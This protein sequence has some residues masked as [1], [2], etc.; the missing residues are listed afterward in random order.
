MFDI[1]KIAKSMMPENNDPLGFL[2]DNSKNT[3]MG[4][5]K[6]YDDE[7]RDNEYKRTT[8]AA[9]YSAR[10]GISYAEA[11]DGLDA[12][13]E[14][15]FKEKV[16]IKTAY[17]K[18]NE[19]LNA[20]YFAQQKQ[21]KEQNLQRAKYDMYSLTPA[22]MISHDTKEMQQKAQKAKELSAAAGAGYVKLSKFMANVGY[23]LS[24]IG[25]QNNFKIVNDQ[26]Y[27]QLK[28]AAD[29]AADPAVKRDLKTGA[30]EVNTYYSGI[31]DELAAKANFK[32][33]F[34][35]SSTDVMDF[36]DNFIKMIL[37]E[38]PSQATQFMLS[39]ATGGMSAPILGMAYTLDKETELELNNP[40]IPEGT[41][42]LNA[43]ATGVINSLD[44]LVDVQIIKSVSNKE[45]KASVMKA[46]ALYVSNMGM[47]AGTEAVQTVAE[48]AVDLL[49][50]VH[51]DY[52]KMSA[53]QKKKILLNGVAES[54]LLGAAF[55][56]G[57]T[58]VAHH[59]M[60]QLD[61]EAYKVKGELQTKA[62]EI[63]AKDNPTDAEI[64]Y[65][66]QIERVIETSDP[67][68]II[69]TAKVA[70]IM[71]DLQS[72]QEFASDE[73]LFEAVGGDEDAFFK[74]KADAVLQN[75]LLEQGLQP[76]FQK[77]K[78]VVNDIQRRFPDVKIEMTQNY[79]TLSDT[80][81]QYYNGRGYGKG[82][83][84][85]YN[86]KTDTVVI[87]ADN[88]KNTDHLEKTFAHETAGHKGLQALLGNEYTSI[89]DEIYSAVNQKH[90]A[91]LQ[92]LAAT[93]GQDL[94]TIEGQRYIIEEYLA[95]QADLQ[96][97]SG[98]KSFVQKIKLALRK[99][100]FRAK[101]TDD[102][103]TTLMRRSLD[104]VRKQRSP[105]TGNNNGARFSIIG[106]K[107]AAALD[108]YSYQNNLDNLLT[109][110]QMLEAGKDAAD[111]KL[112]T[113]W[114]KGGDGKW[115][116]EI[117]DVKLKT[118][119]HFMDGEEY[120]RTLWDITHTTNGSLEEYFEAP[121]L[122]AA[123]PQLKDINFKIITLPNGYGGWYSRVKNEIAVSDHN[124]IFYMNGIEKNL[125]NGNT[126]YAD[127][128]K[129]QF[130]AE[131][132]DIATHEIQHAIQYIEGFAK[133]GTLRQFENNPQINPTY[134]K[135]SEDIK[136]AEEKFKNSPDFDLI[137]KYTELLDQWDGTESEEQLRI[138]DEINSIYEQLKEHGTWASVEKYFDDLA[139]L[140]TVQKN[141]APMDSYKALAG[142]V[143]ARNAAERTDMSAE[144]KRNSLLAETEDV[145]EESKIYIFDNDGTSELARGNLEDIENLK[146]YAK[147]LGVPENHIVFK[148]LSR[149]GY[150]SNGRNKV[151]LESN[152]VLSGLG[153]HI[154][155]IGKST[156]GGIYF[157]EFIDNFE[158][159]FNGKRHFNKKSMEGFYVYSEPDGKPLYTL[160]TY[161]K[162]GKEYFK[163]F[164]GHERGEKETK[165]IVASLR[166]SH[167][168]LS[169]LVLINPQPSHNVSPNPEKSS[170]NQENLR[171][172]IAPVIEIEQ[173]E[174]SDPLDNEY[175]Q[176]MVNLRDQ[177]LAD[178]LNARIFE[179]AIESY[180]FTDE[181]PNWAE[182]SEDERIE[183]IH[184]DFD[185]MIEEEEEYL[186]SE[187]QSEVRSEQGHNE[188]SA[189]NKAAEITR[190][191]AEELGYDVSKI[192][193]NKNGTSFYITV[194]YE[195]SHAAWKLRI[196]DHPQPPGGS[197][198]ER[199]WGGGRDKAD[200]E[201]V[202][203]N[204]KIDLSPIWQ[205]LEEHA[206]DNGVRFSVSPQVDT[207]AFKNWF[208]DS[209]VVDENG[210]PLVVYHGSSAEFTVFSHKFAMRNGAAD[211]RGFYFTSDKSKAEGYKTEDGKLFEV[212]LSLQNPLNPNELT[213]TKNEI[214][215]IIRA[216]D[217]DGDY[218]SNYAEDDRGYPGKAWF[219]KAVKRAAT[220]I[221]ES[222]DDNADIIAEI[223]SSFGQGDA[224][225]K[226]TETIGYDGFIKDDVFVVFNPTQIKSATDNV[227]TFDP[228]NPDIRFSVS[229]GDGFVSTADKENMIT[230][231]MGVPKKDLDQMNAAS[232][233]A[234]LT[235]KKFN[236]P[237][238]NVAL[239]ALNTAKARRKEQM[240]R[241]ADKRRHDWL[242][243]NVDFYR[244][245][246]DFA[247]ED[248]TIRP[249]MR[250]KDEEFSGSF[251]A[252]EFR[253]YGKKRR[254]RDNESDKQ[255]KNY[256]NRREK[257]LAKAQGIYSDELA[258]H[259]ANEYGQD[260]S[261]VEQKLIDFFRDLKWSDLRKMYSDYVAGQNAEFKELDKRME[262]EWK[263][264]QDIVR[265]EE[266]YDII[267]NKKAITPEW[268]RDNR[269]TFNLL[270]KTVLNEDPPKNIPGKKE[271]AAF[272]VAMMNQSDNAPAMKEAFKI[273]YDELYLQFNDKFKDFKE[274]L[275]ADKVN[276]REVQT[277]AKDFA[278]QHIDR[279]YREQFISRAIRLGQYSKNPTGKY[280]QGRRQFELEKLMA[281]M[282]E[283][284]ENLSKQKNI[285]EINKLLKNNKT[286][287]TAK[288]VPFSDM[289]ERQPVIDRIA[290][291][292]KMSPETVAGVL[293]YE[294]ETKQSLIENIEQLND[295]DNDDQQNKIAEM[296]NQLHKIEND[297]YYLQKFGAL[298]LK[299]A[300]A[301][302]NALNA[303]NQFIHEGKTEF[304]E[305]KL[306]AMEKFQQMRINIRKEMNLGSLT[307]PA[308]AE[309]DKHVNPVDNYTYMSMSLPDMLNIFSNTDSMTAYDQSQ[310]GQFNQMIDNATQTEQTM[311]LDMQ[312]KFEKTLA[313]YGIDSIVKRGKFLRG[314]MQEEDTGVEI[315]LYAPFVKNNQPDWTKGRPRT[316]DYVYVDHAR[317]ILEDYNAGHP[318]ILLPIRRNEI[319][320]KLSVMKAIREDFKALKANIGATFTLA[321]LNDKTI[322][323]YTDTEGGNT[324]SHDFK[325][326]DLPNVKKFME[327]KNITPIKMSSFTLH[328][329]QEQLI[330]YDAGIT[331][332]A[333]NNMG[334]D[335]DI[336]QWREH[337]DR[338]YKKHDTVY[339]M[340]ENP[341][342]M[343]K[344][345][346]LKL[347][348][349]AAVQLIL[350]WEQDHYRP[351]MEWNGYSEQT[352][353]QLKVFLNKKNPAYLAV[354]Y[355]LRDYVKEHQ[356]AL[357][358]AVFER[359][360]VHLPEQQNFWYADFG[361]NA[362]DQVR[363]AGFGNQ[364][365][366]LTVSAN[367]LTGR[368]LHWNAPSTHANAFTL[369]LRKQ[370][371]QAH[372]VAW[373]QPIRTLRAVYNDKSVQFTMIKNFGQ[374]AWNQFKQK[375]EVLASGG[376]AACAIG[377]FFNQF[378]S[379][380]TPSNIA[381]NPASAI[382]QLVG[383]LNYAHYVPVDKLLKYLPEANPW[384]PEYRQWREY[385]MRQDFLK[386]R[387]HGAGLNPN[388]GGLLNYSQ[389]GKNISPVSDAVMQYSLIMT[390]GSDA[391]S[392]TTWGY[393][394]FK[395]FEETAKAKG[396]KD[397]FDFAYRWW[398]KATE[399]TQQ[400]GYLKDLNRFSQSSGWRALTIYM[401]NPM[402]T[403][404]LELTA[405][406]KML[407]NPTT[408]NKKDFLKKFIVNH[409]ISSTAMNL[410]SSIFRHG[411]D[412]EEWEEDL[413]N[414]IAGWLLGSFDS[415]FVAGQMATGLIAVLS[416]DAFS[417]LQKFN[418]LPMFN[419]LVRDV[420]NVRKM[421]K[422][423]EFDWLD[424]LNAIG[425]IMMMGGPIKTRT[426]GFAISA[427]TKQAK[428][429]RRWFDED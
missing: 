88:I 241:L 187:S 109:A 394:A 189:L 361:G 152:A 342:Y 90:G 287:R 182:M 175:Y 264:Q 257:A 238:E 424:S 315:D 162:N 347:T 196:S 423:G 135:V 426:A 385:V 21:Q 26:N 366:G 25:A 219:D 318:I 344:K 409:L 401:T 122:F 339:F 331:P 172:S 34:A 141:L 304:R 322:R 293:R 252:Q 279:G 310:A 15:Y 360:G 260:A 139:F 137:Q 192:N 158:K 214:E 89:I 160:R 350:T 101:W 24:K 232:A 183:H 362:I 12:F 259:I 127:F 33:D 40:E 32:A 236:V 391:L 422:N 356:A 256:L 100:G 324:I 352:I 41:R 62:Q 251:I 8:L 159:A 212:Y 313:Q 268:I 87:F 185:G 321:K 9:Y 53:E 358:K 319:T 85:Y 216:I 164:Y 295:A 179:N 282:L 429:V 226:I 292:V 328:G 399:K 428:R 114:E 167:R 320:D 202:I 341:E 220:M 416:D 69:Q 94:N 408:G 16:D 374:A 354:G 281:E 171:F 388:I 116:M 404:A 168:L 155:E 303:L 102:E 6:G 20:A 329:V 163:S 71:S 198:R 254:Q 144:E 244:H 64:A 70:N 383:G 417:A 338:N 125:A 38:A 126:E 233:M 180:P 113:G 337:I 96:K 371:E 289:R 375:I 258:Q 333:Q 240:K 205:F 415:L 211:G 149:Q 193:I 246:V 203:Q 65:L 343:T 314:T 204:D 104:N 84:G 276:V 280:P 308:A 349:G 134:K 72:Q 76:D 228:N 111:I 403:A 225:A 412:F 405:L 166:T 209:K 35:S 261:E 406:T 45:L 414:Y 248:F 294:F 157:Q 419:D 103:I 302:E 17:N 291:I 42:L 117:P 174:G 218:V 272:N 43:F 386:N 368:R 30:T 47:E 381:L 387:L 93:Y 253:K 389:K 80:E 97:L 108:E 119:G 106:E 99:V 263:R 327:Q 355:A 290:Q 255:Y 334:D 407:K 184:K 181:F 56:G 230:V 221:Y 376:E 27:A 215:K 277:A 267:N 128:L 83:G 288:N 197:Y 234:Y 239:S 284:Q 5:Y 36:A 132:Q 283:F 393:A 156:R 377:S 81:K 379:K 194:D 311:L 217:V 91:E 67:M 10:M 227:G 301:V 55:G 145:A 66:D 369:F 74:A 112:A 296:L 148:I 427:F 425:N 307:S 186:L 68:A 29:P 121:E 7:A 176:A 161:E 39:A 60:A 278:Y 266:V 49:S 48:N 245:A 73:E 37:I 191:Y 336:I 207:P 413:D 11:F 140:K 195:D 275:L 398:M 130:F 402:Q 305:S 124:L 118:I 2:D 190:D 213:I 28:T 395:Y 380:W 178:T 247:G 250:F 75:Q 151:Y 86:D 365:G 346:Q 50:G 59:S 370:L 400:S 165:K 138:E 123:Y 285:A 150:I 52:S 129:E 57:T 390:T 44:G 231:L 373:T 78:I 199:E 317:R 222:S 18:L 235:E 300:S 367:F 58:A 348:S 312:N 188:F 210:N 364:S 286:R 382:K 208:K 107:G 298:D 359:Y 363:D 14:Q 396:E 274:K 397:V 105:R 31:Y 249:S 378:Y 410:I 271:L 3:L 326:S 316:T 170:E 120:E 323:V 115:R 335:I 372:F 143:E 79:D 421:V 345:H 273:A 142:E 169:N 265:Q 353:E 92:K 173:F 229:D 243:E 131:I 270:W 306:A 13:N 98:F 147:M 206:P 351:V 54:A 420:T 146:T 242:Y 237:D 309:L 269:A 61:G 4:I 200:V 411:F 153:K 262:E 330:Q 82:Y 19:Q 133:G 392:A 51:G 23:G 332:E 177:N 46:A 299:K 95:D 201:A 1:D 223:Y 63:R 340:G 154:L 136:N 357:D 418:F 224:L 384:N 297:I 22:N 110:K 325:L 77:F